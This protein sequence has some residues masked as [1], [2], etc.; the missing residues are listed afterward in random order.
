MRQLAQR[1]GGYAGL[2]LVRTAKTIADEMEVWL[3]EGG[4]AGLNVMF[5][6]CRA[7]STPLRTRSCRNSRRALFRR[8]YEGATL[9][10]HLGLPRPENRFFRTSRPTET[11]SY[12]SW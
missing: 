6:N 9:R 7:A 8:Q 12:S 11:T 10:E 4:S 3:H 2:A 1:L 5:P